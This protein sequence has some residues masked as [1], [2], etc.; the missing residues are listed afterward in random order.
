VLEFSVALPER[1]ADCWSWRARLRWSQ[2]SCG[3]SEPEGSSH[4][5]LLGQ[6]I[7]GSYTKPFH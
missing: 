5:D 3:C 6:L 2:V 4:A 7:D 1:R